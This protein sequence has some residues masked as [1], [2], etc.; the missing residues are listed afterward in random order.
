MASF[1]CM[2]ASWCSGVQSNFTCCLVSK[3]SGFAIFANPLVNFLVSY[4]SEE[5]SD[6]FRCCWWVHFLNCV[7]FRG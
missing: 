7:C 1:K 4:Q 3:V 6:L 2:K 5:G